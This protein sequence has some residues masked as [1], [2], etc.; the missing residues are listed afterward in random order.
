MK[1]I[2][3]FTALAFAFSTQLSFACT[4]DTDS[5]VS[6]VDEGTVIAPD[7]PDNWW[8]FTRVVE[9]E[10]RN[11]RSGGRPPGGLGSWE[12]RWLHMIRSHKESQENYEKYVRYI[13]DTRRE[14]GLPDLPGYDHER[15]E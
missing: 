7:T 10:A 11:E 14:L 4:D 15:S 1:R 5:E 3:R 12:Q 2:I 8:Q 6:S 13:V 9:S